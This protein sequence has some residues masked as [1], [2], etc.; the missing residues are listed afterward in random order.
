MTHL[1]WRKTA[2][3]VLLIL[4]LTGCE[5]LPG[6]KGSQGAVIGGVSGAAVGAAVGGEKHRVLGA[7]VGG[8]LGAGGGYVIGANADKITGKDRQGAETAA[9]QSQEQP[10][11]AEQAKNATT[12]DINMDGFVTLDE[13]VAM[14]QAGFDDAKLIER[15][16]ATN[17]VF[18]LTEGQRQYLRERGVSDAVINQMTEINK[19]GRDRILSTDDRVISRPAPAT[20]TTR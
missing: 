7:I 19:V 16:R 6:D 8:V 12:A 14:K 3:A 2:L 10:A 17:Q 20:P 11:T 9:R 15:L 18:D 4:S 1:D 5:N 13:V